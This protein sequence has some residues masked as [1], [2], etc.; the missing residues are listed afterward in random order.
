MQPFATKGLGM[1]CVEESVGLKNRG[2]SP[3]TWHVGS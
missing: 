2:F 3:G 1:I